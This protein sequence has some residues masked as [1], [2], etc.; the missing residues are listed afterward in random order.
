MNNSILFFILLSHA[1]FAKILISVYKPDA[2][3]HRSTDILLS[4]FTFI[5]LSL[6]FF[7]L[8]PPFWLAVYLI[9]YLSCFYQLR[10]LYLLKLDFVFFY[11]VSTPWIVLL[12]FIGRFAGISDIN[13]LI[14]A[15][16]L[17]F[18]WIAYYK[19]LQSKGTKPK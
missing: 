15:S 19:D 3:L 11:F 2:I 5:I 10:R 17:L 9:F 13:G 1:L 16:P 8:T 12:W 4:G 7:K 18:V 6:A 14:A